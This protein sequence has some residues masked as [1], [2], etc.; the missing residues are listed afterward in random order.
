MAKKIQTVTTEM[1]KPI[2]II[3]NNGQLKGLPKNP[4]LIKDENFE[5]LKKS[6]TDCPEMTYIREV[7]VFPLNENYIVIAG[8]MRFKA[9]E[10]LKFKTIPCKIL[11]KSTPMNVVREIAIK[12]NNHSGENDWDL[13]SSD[14]DGEELKD[15]GVD[16]FV[17]STLDVDKFLN[18]SE[19]LDTERGTTKL[20]FEY[21]NEDYEKV[22][23]AL[24]ALGKK[25]EDVLFKLLK[26]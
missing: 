16:V 1:L 23:Q 17:A 19:E 9:M 18:E 21:S 24:T 12:D 6:I 8:N 10:E 11:H 14:W 15:W 26:L 13:I 3:N 5:K 2:Q 25:K 7:V 20:V 4:R 22:E